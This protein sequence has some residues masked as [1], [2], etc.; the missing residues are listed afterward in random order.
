MYRLGEAH[1]VRLP[2]QPGAGQA[3]LKEKQWTPVIAPYLSA[4]VPEVIRIGEPAELFPETWAIVNWLPGEL[5]DACGPNTPGARWRQ[6][7]AADLADFIQSLRAIAV[8]EA[9]TQQSGLRGYRGSPLAAFD[10]TFRKNVDDCRQIT[11]LELDLDAALVVWD[12]A[13]KLP[14]AATTEPDCWYHSDLV[15]ENL[16]LVDGRLSA[17]LDFGGLAVGDPTIDLHGAWELF[18]QPSLDLFRDRLGASESQ[19]LRGRAW[20]LAI[21][22]GCFS[23][24]WS[25]MP[26]RCRDRLAM[27]QS[28]I[29]DAAR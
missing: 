18:D 4:A 29:S 28:V 13:L 21:A 24:Y 6:Q 17:V 2:R 16:L 15:A 27:A 11:D 22:L 7:L 10:R 5:P 3:I 1:L 20:A 23:Y 12:A 14:G 19:W 25:T 9:A 26:G 8:T